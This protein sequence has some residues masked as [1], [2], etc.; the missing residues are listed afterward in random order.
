MHTSDKAFGILA[1]QHREMLLTYIQTLVQDRNLAED[2]VQETLVA[3][4]QHLDRFRDGDNFGAW[5]RGI[6]RNKARMNRRAHAR[7]A[8]VVDSRIVEGMEDIYT[9]FDRPDSAWEDKLEAMRQ[10]VAKLTRV[11]REAVRLC[12]EQGLSLQ[13]AANRT[14]AS[15]A[16]IGQRL[17]RARTE[18]RHCVEIRLKGG[19]A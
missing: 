10:C 5:L 1:Q 18:I 3:A 9:V 12:Y 8:L 2:I 4:F 17:H 13:D 7:R 16:A 14:L 19:Q 11:L 15:A 6:A